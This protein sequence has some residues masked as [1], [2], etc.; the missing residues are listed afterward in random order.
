[1]NRRWIAALAVAATVPAL[2]TATAASAQTAPAG[3]VDA[4]KHQFVNKHGVTISETNTSS[5]NGANGTKVITKGKIQFGRSGPAASDTTTLIDLR[6]LDLGDEFKDLGAPVRTVVTKGA[7]YSK[8]GIYSSLLPEGK[9]WLRLPPGS[10]TPIPTSGLVNVLDPT[11][12]KA[13]IGT[14]DT[15]R[16]SGTLDGTRTTLHKGTITL[17]EL[18]KSSKS[19]RDTLGRKPAGKSAKLEVSW[20]LWLGKDQL[21]RRLETSW[22]QETVGLRTVKSSSKSDI[23]FSG[24]GAKL[25]IKAPPADQIADY[26]DLEAAPPQPSIPLLPLPQ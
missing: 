4:L 5:T 25:D 13:V 1:M 2:A 18:Y 9:S 23:R 16:A 15:K 26:K 19:F 12:L 17:S 11:T 3:P 14:T 22:V 20:C 7:A 24:W 10:I 21:P 8:G 6:G